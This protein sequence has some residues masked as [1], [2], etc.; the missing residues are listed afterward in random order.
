MTNLNDKYIIRVTCLEF[1]GYYC[2]VNE[3]DGH[4]EFS[5]NEKD[6]RIA[7]FYTRAKAREVIINIKRLEQFS[8]VSKFE[9]IKKRS[10]FKSIFR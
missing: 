3:D 9:I 10:L 8:L 1:L 4:S 7:E 6:E 5:S 2:K